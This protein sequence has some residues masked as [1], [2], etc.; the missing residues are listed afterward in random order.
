MGWMHDTLEYFAVDPIG[1]RGTTTSITFAMIYEYSERFINPLSHDEV[2]HGKKSLVA[3][4]PGPPAQQFAN[5]RLLYAYMWTR[6]GRSSSSWGASWRPG[7]S[8]TKSAAPSGTSSDEP[9]HRGVLGSSPRWARC[10][11]ER[12]ACWRTTT[13]PRRSSG[14][15]ASTA[16]TPSSPTCV[17]MATTTSSSC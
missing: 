16:R 13:K 17:A 2:V 7:G 1:R 4:M 8:G 6:P 9:F 15:T 10:Y 14:S 11:R 12:P 3:K 5:L